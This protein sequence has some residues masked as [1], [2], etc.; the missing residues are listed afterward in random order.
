VSSSESERVGLKRVSKFENVRDWCKMDMRH[1]EQC[2][3]SW[4]VVQAGGAGTVES[5]IYFGVVVVRNDDK[6]GGMGEICSAMSGSTVILVALLF[7]L[8]R[9]VTNLLSSP[10]WGLPELLTEL[11]PLRLRLLLLLLLLLTDCDQPDDD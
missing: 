3:G 4:N 11:L 1:G 2:G 5:G 9:A 10:R 8:G 6:T 7:P